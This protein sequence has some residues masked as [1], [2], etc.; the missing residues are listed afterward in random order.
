MVVF[1]D[2]T[3]KEASRRGG[4]GKEVYE[5]AEMQ[6]RVRELFRGLG[7]VDRTE[8]EGVERDEDVVVVDAGGSVEGVAKSVWEVVERRVEEVDTGSVGE[9]RTIE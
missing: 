9:V 7:G 4:W 1:L 6:R 2:L 8:A 3:P 5:K